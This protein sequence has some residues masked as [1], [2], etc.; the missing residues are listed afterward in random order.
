MIIS[1]L[2]ELRGL[3]GECLPQNWEC[4][5]ASASYY[6]NG[7]LFQP[8]F[9]HSVLRSWGWD[10]VNYIFPLPAVRLCGSVDRVEDQGGSLLAAC[11]CCLVC[12]LLNI[13]GGSSFQFHPVVSSIASSIASQQC[14]A[15]GAEP[16]PRG[17]P[18]L[19]S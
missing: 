19:N 6:S 5:Q 7:A 8:T 16:L 15:L 11:Q 14:P 12:P 3:L 10:L 4:F 17:L 18:L 1:S 13:T 2:L 9:P